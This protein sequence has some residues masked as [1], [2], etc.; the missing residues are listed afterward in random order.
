MSETTEAPEG[1]PA[2]EPEPTPAPEPAPDTDEQTPDPVPPRRE[3]DEAR[4]KE[5]RRIRQLVAKNA[6]RDRENEELRRELDSYRRQAQQQAPQNETPEQTMRRIELEAEQRAEAKLLARR[7][8][9]EGNAQYRDW[10][11]KTKDLID[12]GA[13]PGMAT[14]L[15]E[16]PGGVRVA[17]ALAEDPTELQRI[18]SIPSERGRAI[19]LGKYAATLDS[20]AGAAPARSTPQV[21]RAPA[22]IRPVTGRAA[23]QFNE[24]TASGQDLVDRYMKQNLENRMRR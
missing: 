20:D 7:F 8:H 3:A 9:E 14:L 4:D 17:A 2:P 15:I 6:A 13:D 1:A 16:M 11:Q 21:T 19:A 18:V 5:D 12:M 24:Y 22:P 10:N 23:P